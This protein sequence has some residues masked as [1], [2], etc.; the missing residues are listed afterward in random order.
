MGKNH[1]E[2]EQDGFLGQSLFSFYS[3]PDYFSLANQKAR[4]FGGG[5]LEERL[6]NLLFNNNT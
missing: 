5:W 2:G 1:T 6:K 4:I 3:N